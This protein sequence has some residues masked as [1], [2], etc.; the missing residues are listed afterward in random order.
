MW[1]SIEKITKNI[2]FDFLFSEIEHN[3][4][5]KNEIAKNWRIK[6]NDDKKNNPKKMKIKREVDL[7][8]ENNLIKLKKEKQMIKLVTKIYNWKG[9]PIDRIRYINE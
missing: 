4:K 9:A 3:A 1:K 5:I 7:S 2:V 8:L 6:F